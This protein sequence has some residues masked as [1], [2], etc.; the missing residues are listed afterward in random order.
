MTP[1]IDATMKAPEHVQTT[2]LLLRKPRAEDAASIFECYASDAAVTRFLS[3]PRHASVDDTRAFL[4]FSD[5][6]WERWPAGPYLVESRETG[7]LLGGTGLA[8][9]DA[10]RAATG[11]VFASSAW[12]RGFATESLRAIVDIARSVGVIRLYA[13]CHADHAASWRV[14]EKS[15]FTREGLLRRHSEFPNLRPGEPCD[16][17]CYALILR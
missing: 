11:Y 15:G 5:A 6:E 13:L 3:W 9:E 2:R 14:L 17:L 1:R 16:V 10:H 12:G 4:Q 7:R 8:F